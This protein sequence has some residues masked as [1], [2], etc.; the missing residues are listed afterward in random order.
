[1]AYIAKKIIHCTN[2]GRSNYQPHLCH[3]SI[4]SVSQSVCVY[5]AK[6]GWNHWDAVCDENS[7]FSKILT[8]FYHA[9]YGLHGICRGRVSV[10]PSVTSWSSTKMAKQRNMQTTPH[11]SSGTLVFL[12]QKPF[13][14]SK[15]VTPNGGAKCRWGRSKLVNFDK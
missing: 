9:S 8:N 15:G 4:S 14:N 1:M 6:S 12:C 3:S 2:V 11:D 5:C 13:R 7:K 10:C